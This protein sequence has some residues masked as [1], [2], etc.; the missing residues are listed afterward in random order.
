MRWKPGDVVVLR[1]IY[2]GRVYAGRAGQVVRDGGDEVLIYFAAGT[3]CHWPTLEGRWLRIPAPHWEL[4]PGGWLPY[5]QLHLMRRGAISHVSVLFDPANFGHVGWKVDFHER[6]RRT[7]LGFDALDWALDIM[8]T[9][10]NE[11]RLKDEDE[12]AS[13]QKEGVLSPNDTELVAMELDRLVAQIRQGQA[14]FDDSL[15]DWRPDPAWTAV[16]L[17]SGWDSLSQFQ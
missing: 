5:H 3:I 2:R 17:P 12:Y 11:W 9:R 15:K 4:K 8:V 1:E 6:A 10:D 7:A 16:P 13:Y 14:P